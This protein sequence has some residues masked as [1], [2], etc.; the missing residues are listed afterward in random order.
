MI[1]AYSIK[2]KRLVVIK[3]T[4]NNDCERNILQ[5]FSQGNFDFDPQNHVVQ[6]LDQ[7]ELPGKSPSTL[8]IMPLLCNFDSPEFD[9][10]GELLDFAE[11]LLEV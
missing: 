5:S 8:L 1:D 6:M 11:Q 10:L 3:L 7:L 2:L 4:F 9:I